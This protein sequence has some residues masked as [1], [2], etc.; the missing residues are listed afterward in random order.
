MIGGKTQ[1]TSSDFLMA[2]LVFIVLSAVALIA[3]IIL[4]I[5]LSAFLPGFVVGIVTLGV[6]LVPLYIVLSQTCNMCGSTEN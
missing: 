4:G 6:S 2:V 3:S 1:L 5:T